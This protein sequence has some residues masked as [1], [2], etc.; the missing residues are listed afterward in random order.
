ME[1]KE[2]VFMSVRVDK[3]DYQ[4]L[5]EVIAPAL[6]LSLSQ[7]VRRMLKE[8]LKKHRKEIK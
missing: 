3:E 6:D 8:F 2:R 1:K 5:K 7:A 4:E